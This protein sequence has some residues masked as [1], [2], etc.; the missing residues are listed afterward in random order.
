[1]PLDLL[2]IHRSVNQ[3]RQLED[4]RATLRDLLQFV[5]LVVSL[6]ISRETIDKD[7]KNTVNLEQVVTPVHKLSLL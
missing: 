3:L 5:G 6:V 2:S 7:N 1:M 4:T